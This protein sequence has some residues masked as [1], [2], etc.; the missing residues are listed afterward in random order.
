MLSNKFLPR[1]WLPTNE[2][3]R[4]NSEGKKKKA[5]ATPLLS[6]LEL[7]SRIPCLQDSDSTQKMFDP[8]TDTFLVFIEWDSHA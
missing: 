2:I 4:G 8:D 3:Y 5:A 1:N 6:H 7:G